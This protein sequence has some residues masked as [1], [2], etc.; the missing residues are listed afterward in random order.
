MPFHHSVFL[1]YY[2]PQFSVHLLL[3]QLAVIVLIVHAHSVLYLLLGYVA[4]FAPLVN[5]LSHPT[6]QLFF[7]K[8]AAL[9]LIELLEDA[10]HI[11]LH[12]LEHALALIEALHNLLVDLVPVSHKIQ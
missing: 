5:F 4:L 12:S 6:S 11:C 3:R 10:L 2:F 7:F 1:K 9:V 8:G